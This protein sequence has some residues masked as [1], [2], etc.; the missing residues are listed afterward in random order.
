MIQYKGIVALAMMLAVTM[1]VGYDRAYGR[2]LRVAATAD[3]KSDSNNASPQVSEVVRELYPNG[4]TKSET[5][6]LGG[7]IHGKKKLFAEN[8]SVL[9]VEE[10]RE[11]KR[12][13]L[14]LEYFEDGTVKSHE[15][16]RDDKLNGDCSM[17]YP[18]GQKMMAG[19]CADGKKSGKWTLYHNNGNKYME[20]SYTEGV[21]EGLWRS[22]SPEGWLD[23]EG[24]Y[25]NGLQVDVWVYYDKY[26][27][28]TRKLTMK[29][30]M[31][32]GPCWIYNQG[33][34]VGEGI[35][36]G[37][38]HD[39]KK[40]GVWKAYFRNGKLKYE[41]IFAMGL[42]SGHF[43]EFYSSGAVKGTGDYSNDKRNGNWVFYARDGVAIDPEKS[44]QYVNGKIRK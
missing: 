13:G 1:T 7:K 41:G 19:Q 21:M 4:K 27:K 6:L 22:Y 9:K 15:T 18:N 35:M 44:G 12:E 29:N 38:A 37:L 43:K 32:D 36:T 2:L 33:R 11:G 5:P 17:N 25:R 10:Y 26:K 8:G 28:I 23:S 31:I 30:G 3:E 20:G 16:Y 24:E 42:R 34:L 14:S 40:N 39:P